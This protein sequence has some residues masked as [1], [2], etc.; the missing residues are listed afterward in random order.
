[1]IMRTDFREGDE[2]GDFSVSLSGGSL[3]GLAIP[4]EILSKPLIH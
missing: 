2:D 3:N 4:V 1:M